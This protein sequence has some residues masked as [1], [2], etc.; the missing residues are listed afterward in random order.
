MAVSVDPWVTPEMIEWEMS[1]RAKNPQ[2]IVAARWK[3]GMFTTGES[4]YNLWELMPKVT[5]PT[6]MITGSDCN[7]VPP[8]MVLEMAK[9]V[10]ASQVSVIENA[11]CCSFYTA[12]KRVAEATLNFLSK[13]PKR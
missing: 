10:P 9:Q 6:L 4:G 8:S 1:E 3:F 5:V 13:L 11:G 12:P 7:R 2:E